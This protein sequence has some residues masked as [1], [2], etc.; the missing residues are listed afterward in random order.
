MSENNITR[1]KVMP[2]NL[3][4]GETN[5][6][7][8]D[9]LSDDQIEQGA[10]SDSDAQ[11][12]SPETLAKFQR[13]IDVQV[14]RERLKLTQEEFAATFHLS[15]DAVINWEQGNTQPDHAARTLLRVI[16]HNPEA[17]KEALAIA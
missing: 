12:T 5:W 2:T 7:A 17:V 11:P 10:L 6:E 16:A 4:N 3:P 8:L 15:I 1:T 14:I 13:P 9:A